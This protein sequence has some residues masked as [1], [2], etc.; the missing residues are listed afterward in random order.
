MAG[1]KETPRQKMI[2]MMYL[3][4]TALLALNVSKSIL[5]A[6]VAI[7]ENTQKGNIA[8]VE[9]GDGY[10]YTV[11]AE[12]GA[13]KATDPKGNKE[14]IK[15]I[16]DALKVMDEIN[17]TTGDM[18][19]MIDDLKL[20]ILKESGEDVSGV[21]P[22]EELS[23]LWSKYDKE[24]PNLP[25]RMNLMAVQ[26]KDQYDVP[27]HIII[28]EDIKKP[29]GDGMKL[30][31]ALLKY[32]SDLMQLA[33]TYEW[34]GKQ[35]KV[36]TKDINQYKTNKDLT[37]M[38]KKM[39]TAESVNPD[40]KE[41]LQ[42]IYSRLTKLE[43]NKVHDLKDVHWIGMTF[44]HSPLVAAIASLSSLQQDILSARAEALYLWKQ[45]ISTGE[46]SFDQIMPLAYGPSFAR[47]GEEVELKVMMAAFDSQSPPEVVV[48]EGME[49]AKISAENGVALVKFNASGSSMDLK[50]TVTIKNKQGVP[51]SKDW[52]ISVPVLTPTGAIELTDLNI[53]YRGYPNKVEASGSGFET[54][55]LSG[56]NVSISGNP[57]SGY[58]VK[59]GN[60]N[61]ATMS[62][63]GRNADGT[64]SVLKKGTYRVS[65]MPDPVLFWGGSKSGIKGSRSSRALIAKYTPEIPLK[66]SFTVTK[67]TASAPGLRG[68]PPQG[69]GGS[70]GPAGAL[71]SAAPP[72]TALSITATVVGPDGI[73]RQ[74]GGSWPL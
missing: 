55:S 46:Y 69:M 49:N 44:D 54:Y 34:G 41:G 7:E 50:G 17:L 66:A 18:I 14:K 72:G 28:G 42:N 56:S 48:T 4:L 9:R 74:I 73:A 24:N 62:I 51:K 3:V 52:S 16:E 37:E 13:L 32:R 31:K 20:K 71:I 65:S 40:D 47:S 22:N 26:A 61:S 33:G 59:P 21:K 15:N 57:S 25:I 2:G 36:E 60:G 70:L 29:T 43:K 35:F 30:W 11:S 38:V 68:A 39:T 12:I 8:M 19:K 23:I 1:G 63:T 45:K 10:Y 27:M 67:W 53:L 64:S 58:V 5:D 6:F